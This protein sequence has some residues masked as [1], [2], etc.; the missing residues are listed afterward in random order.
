V[1]DILM[2][3]YKK[4]TKM[5]RVRT[6]FSF[7]EDGNIKITHYG[8]Y[9]QGLTSSEIEDYLRARANKIA[10]KRLYKKFCNIAGVNTMA[11]YGCPN[12]EYQ[13]SLM[14]RHDVK[15]F[16]DVLFVVTKGTYF[17]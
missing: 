3:K 12:C 10:V 15:R 7:D 16:S 1:G 4:P 17:D 2:A 9:T 5:E 8:K 14:Y 11:M 6:K 13:T